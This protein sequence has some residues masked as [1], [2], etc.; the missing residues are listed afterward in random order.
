MKQLLLDSSVIIKWFKSEKEDKIKEALN[1]L[2]HYTD[3]K[4]QI[5]IPA[6][7]QYELIN[8]AEFDES[9][10]AEVWNLNIRKFFELNLKVLSLDKKIAEDIYNFGKSQNVSA[11]DASYIILA[12]EYKIDFITA[13]QKL[14][15]KVNLPFVKSL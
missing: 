8:A 13:D 10:P 3:G 7:T 5:C 9:L 4:I 14:V 2:D 6:I 12:K 15:K 11:Y 1:F